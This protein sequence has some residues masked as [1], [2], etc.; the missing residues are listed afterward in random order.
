[1]NA[2]THALLLSLAISTVSLATPAVLSG[3]AGQSGQTGQAQAGQSQAAADKESY[4]P[5][6]GMP[7]RDAV[8]VPTSH[9]MIEKMLDVAKV[10][11][12]DFVMDLGSGDGRAIIAAAKRGVRGRGVEF[13]PELVEFSKREAA[14]AG[15]ADKAEF[16]QGDMYEADISK[17]TVLALFLL[18]GNLEK[19]KGKFL[20]LPPGSRIVANTFWVEGWEPDHT[21]KLE[22]GCDS[23]CTA[24]LFII[25]AKVEGTWRM[26]DGTLT[27]KQT[28]QEVSGTLQARGN[29]QPVTGKLRGEEISLS[30]GDAEY[31]GKVAGGRMQGT[32]KSSSGPS[33]WS[34]TKS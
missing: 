4:K 34:A 30:V 10:T 7:G 17:A 9:A 29:S 15:V 6:V 1:M 20:D 19:L 24:H 3:A 31:S 13:N 23:W 33:A 8:W 32:V 26:G 18:P 11:P 21:E 2:R 28:H 27:L 16:V 22:E 14:A 25:P 5:I 12:K